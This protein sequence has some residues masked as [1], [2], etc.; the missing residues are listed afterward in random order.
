MK[1]NSN[2]QIVKRLLELSK[3]QL[4]YSTFPK[5]FKEEYI[6]L[7]NLLNDALSVAR[8]EFSEAFQ[9]AV[10]DYKGSL[11][12]GKGYGWFHNSENLV[13]KQ[14]KVKQIQYAIYGDEIGEIK[15]NEELG[16]AA[17][18]DLIMQIDRTVLMTEKELKLHNKEMSVVMKKIIDE[19][20]KEEK[21]K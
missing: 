1:D 8:K 19:I 10:G 5:P 14:T 6:W 12:E 21:N 20:L 18:K 9:K 13:W 17:Y 16:N 2:L 7:S 4:D 15:F 11:A 3:N